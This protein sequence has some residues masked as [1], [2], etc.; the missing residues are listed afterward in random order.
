[1]AGIGKNMCKTHHCTVVNTVVVSVAFDGSPH[2][3]TKRVNSMQTWCW[4]AMRALLLGPDVEPF[5]GATKR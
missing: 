2:G 3:A 4:A 5:D 1:M